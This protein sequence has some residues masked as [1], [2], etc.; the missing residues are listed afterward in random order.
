MSKIKIIEYP[1]SLLIRRRLWTVKVNSFRKQ[2]ILTCISNGLVLVAPLS[3]FLGEN[4]HSG[5]VTP[6]RIREYISQG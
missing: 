6:G 4:T 2:V 3:F 5:R 1:K